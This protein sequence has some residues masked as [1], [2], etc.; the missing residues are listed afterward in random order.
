MPYRKRKRFVSNEKMNE[1]IIIGLT[2]GLT[3]SEKNAEPMIF[4]FTCVELC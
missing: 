1:K 4:V 3:G 2:N